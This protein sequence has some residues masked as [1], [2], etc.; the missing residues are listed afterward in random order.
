[1]IR[2]WHIIEGGWKL[3]EKYEKKTT[4]RYDR[5]GFFRLDVKYTHPIPINTEE[6][7]VIS[8]MMYPQEIP[9][10]TND[11]LFYGAREAAALWA[12][13]RFSTVEDYICLGR[14]REKTKKKF[15]PRDCIPKSFYVIYC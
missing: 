7:A 10:G 1:M 15:I 6:T 11:R 13:D 3:L 2:Q 4:S 9:R 12:S 5:I 14:S 8:A